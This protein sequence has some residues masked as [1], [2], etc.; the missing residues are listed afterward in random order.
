MHLRLSSL[1]ETIWNLSIYWR[2]Y[3]GTICILVHERVTER[4]YWE[5]NTFG[6]RMKVN[7]GFCLETNN[8]SINAQCLG[9]IILLSFLVFGWKIK[10]INTYSIYF[11]FPQ[12]SLTS[13]LAKTSEV[14]NWTA[15]IRFIFGKY[16]L[17]QSNVVNKINSSRPLL[18]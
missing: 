9:N 8:V 7:C 18:L 11:L 13:T 6:R 16:W 5:L 14:L 4:V 15:N 12:K 1:R 3:V 2:Y 10:K 17:S